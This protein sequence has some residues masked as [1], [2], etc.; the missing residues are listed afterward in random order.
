MRPLALALV[1]L[2][3]C[4]DPAPPVA[5]ADAEAARLLEAV[6][7]SAVAD[8]FAALD[9]TTARADLVVTALDGDREAGR[10]ALTVTQ[11]PRGVAV[12]ARTA[13]GT[14]ADAAD[15]PP[16]LRDPIAHALSD[17]PPYL[18][19]AA[20][21]AYRL[22]VLGDTTIGGVAFRLVEATLVDP[23]S[24]LG[25][26]R[27]W[28][29]VTDAGRVAAV[30]VEREARST[31]YDEA[32]RVRV[33]LAPHAGGWVPRRVVTDTRTDV[34]LSPPSHVRTEW[35]VRVVGGA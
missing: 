14:L 21:E 30:E 9:G 31:L 18:D 5:P 32:S 8:A 13:S 34:P 15:A 2:A 7:A 6:D 22:T 11:T 1:L 17:D 19:P 20:R 23:A 4:A 16:R 3:G 24:G 12:S 10:E 35:T 33:D 26:R 27:V 28:A 29:A 25:I